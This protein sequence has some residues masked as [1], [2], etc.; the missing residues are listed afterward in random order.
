MQIY[1]HRNDQQ[2]GPFTE[3]EV[4]AQVAAGTISPQDSVWWQGQ[5]NWIPLAQSSLM[6]G[7][8]VTAGAGAMPPV[9]VAQA[10]S[11]YATYALIAGC[12][13]LLCGI[14]ASIP[15]IIFGHMGLKEIK[16]NPGLQGQG[17]ALAGL[18]LG[19]IFS[20]LI[21]LYLGIVA[22]S[23]FIALG[24]QT[25]GTFKT[26]D[27]QL[28]AAQTND[29][30]Q[31]PASPDQTAPITTPGPST[32]SALAAPVN[33]PDSSATNSTPSTNAPPDGT[34]NAAPMSQ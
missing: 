19:Y 20:A 25:K 21:V 22:I 17:M 4:H 10:S 16:K 9:G 13:S 7:G 32:N 28:K 5:P 29:A 26:I 31:T 27:S 34:T 8:A 30:D 11:K 23:V 33:A 6:P 2:L 24:N 15:A 3:A 18:I 14:F 12:L 1:I